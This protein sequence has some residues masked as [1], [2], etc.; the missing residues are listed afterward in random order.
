MI[1]HRS[2]E[3]IDVLLVEDNPGDVR[4][5][6]EAFAE[7]KISNDLHVVRDGESALDFVYRRG[8]YES[9]P[10]PDLVLLD[11][12]LPKIDGTE[13]L[14]EIKTDDAL[15][16]IPVIVL[17]SSSAEED[18]VES[19]ELHSNAYLTK[20]VD[21]DEFVEL[22]QS[23]EEFWFTLVKLPPEPEAEPTPLEGEE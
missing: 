3:P 20:P 12:N 16:R 11:L 8:D 18:I 19:Y 21:P 6:E 5:T 7:A 22:V 4:L 13:V 9:A 14:E 10:T 23:F 15:K 17:T 1:E 2:A